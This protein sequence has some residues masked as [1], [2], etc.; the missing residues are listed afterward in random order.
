MYQPDFFE[1]MEMALA[2][3]KQALAMGHTEA[4]ERIIHDMEWIIEK[5]RLRDK[6]KISA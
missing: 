4:I 6:E 1:E 5:Q 3:M 2:G